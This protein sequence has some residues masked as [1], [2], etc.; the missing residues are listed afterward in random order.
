MLVKEKN[1]RKL[2]SHFWNLIL[3]KITMSTK[4]TIT[5]MWQLLKLPFQDKC[6]EQSEW[7]GV[8]SRNEKRITV[9]ETWRNHVQEKGWN[10]SSILEGYSCCQHDFHKTQYKS[11]ITLFKPRERAFKQFKSPHPRCV[12]SIAFLNRN[13]IDLIKKFCI[14]LENKITDYIKMQDLRFSQQC[15]GGGQLLWIAGN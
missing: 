10:S 4:T 15:E 2:F 12:K 6:V 11:W 3:I 13:A 8:F 14:K 1:Y 5:I 9:S 7:T